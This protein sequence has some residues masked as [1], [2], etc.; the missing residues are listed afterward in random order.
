[1]TLLV[2]LDRRRPLL[3]KAELGMDPQLALAVVDEML[4]FARLRLAKARLPETVR[5][6]NRLLAKTVPTFRA[7]LGDFFGG[8]LSRAGLGSVAKDDGFAFDPESID[9]PDE[10]GELTKVIRALYVKL[11]GSAFESIAQEL[12][13]DVKFDLES[14]VAAGIRSV[15]GNRVT[16][17]L[18]TTRELIRSYVETSIERGYS[19]DQL[20]AG[21]D[22][23][24]FLG[25]GAI[26][27]ERAQTIALTET[28]TAYN[29]SSSAAYRDS[30]LVETVL[31]FDGPECGWTEH[32]DPDL[33]DGSVRSLDDADEYPTSHPNCQR[34]FGPIV[35]ADAEAEA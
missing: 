13:V 3:A 6:R 34:A 17:I 24:G 27:A 35:S 18:E 12:G 10:T 22:D 9:W 29:L 21:V 4:G 25:L 19:V 2:N 31:V 30:G 15:V 16:G 33:A 14:K 8:L 7:E 11:G 32:D 26:F 23:D 5:A 20:V 1:M 28:A